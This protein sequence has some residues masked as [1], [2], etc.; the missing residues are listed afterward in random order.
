MACTW[1]SGGGRDL[2]S[3][4]GCAA[5]N[6]RLSF[7]ACRAGPRSSACVRHRELVSV[8]RVV[9]HSLPFYGMQDVIV[10]LCEPRHH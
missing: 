8:Q 7:D 4:L 10:A 3:A 6:T 2:V 5:L 9:V 1:D